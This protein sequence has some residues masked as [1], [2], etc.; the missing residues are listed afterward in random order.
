MLLR[1]AERIISAHIGRVDTTR[2]VPNLPQPRKLDPPTPPTGAF[3]D[4]VSLSMISG[5][6]NDH[7]GSYRTPQSVNVDEKLVA[8]VQAMGERT[9]I[10]VYDETRTC[11]FSIEPQQTWLPPNF[12]RNAEGESLGWAQHIYEG[13][14]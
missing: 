8:K 10:L 7:R 9:P 14:V 3:A 6:T 12:D 11:K 4:G 5:G 13:F 1:T 2:N